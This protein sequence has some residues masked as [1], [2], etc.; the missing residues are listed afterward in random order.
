V[1]KD[2]GNAYIVTAWGLRPAAASAAAEMG[3]AARR[4]ARMVADSLVQ[5]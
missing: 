5:R 4:A 3:L 2:A 1:F